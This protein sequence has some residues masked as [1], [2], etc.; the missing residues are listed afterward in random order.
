MCP[1][2]IHFEKPMHTSWGASW[3][4]HLEGLVSGDFTKAITAVKEAAAAAFVEAT[5]RLCC[6]LR[7]WPVKRSAI[8]VINLTPLVSLGV[9]MCCAASFVFSVCPKWA[10]YWKISLKTSSFILGKDNKDDDCC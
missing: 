5:W 7:P 9:W 4:G 8:A 3:T 6:V 1:W 2:Y 10:N